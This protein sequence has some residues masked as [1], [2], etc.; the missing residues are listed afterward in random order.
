MKQTS[1][2]HAQAQPHITTPKSDLCGCVASWIL[3]DTNERGSGSDTHPKRALARENLRLAAGC[4]KSGDHLR[5]LKIIN[6]T[7]SPNTSSYFPFEP[8]IYLLKGVIYSE[9]KNIKK[10]AKQV[11]MA[12]QAFLDCLHY[13]DAA[14][15]IKNED[16]EILKYY[17]FKNLGVLYSNSHEYQSASSCMTQARTF[18]STAEQ[19][20]DID[21]THIKIKFAAG[22]HQEA[23]QM[24]YDALP[25]ALWS[26]SASNPRSV[27]HNAKNILTDILPTLSI[28]LA[29]LKDSTQSQEATETI[30]KQF[31][32]ATA[33][34][35]GIA[36]MAY[37]DKLQ[38]VTTCGSLD[39]IPEVAFLQFI[40]DQSPTFSDLIRIVGQ[41]PAEIE[42]F[43]KR[44]ANFQ[45]L[46]AMIAK[47]Q[48]TLSEKDDALR[49]SPY[50]V[51]F[52]VYNNLLSAYQE[53]QSSYIAISSDSINRILEE[54][55][56]VLAF[57]ESVE[58]YLKVKATTNQSLADCLDQIKAIE[59]VREG[60]ISK[61]RVCLQEQ[62]PG[63]TCKKADLEILADE[64]ISSQ[65]SI[66][67]L[68]KRYKSNDMKKLYDCLPSQVSDYFKQNQINERNYQAMSKLFHAHSVRL[69][70]KVLSE[71]AHQLKNNGLSPVE[72]RSAKLF[73]YQAITCQCHPTSPDDEK[74]KLCSL[75]ELRSSSGDD[76]SVANKFLPI[77]QAKWALI[78]KVL[79]SLRDLQ[80]DPQEF[81]QS[82]CDTSRFK[83]KAAKHLKLSVIVPDSKTII[84]AEQ[85]D[86][87][88]VISQ[89]IPCADN[90]R[91]DDDITQSLAFSLRSKSATIAA[92]NI[93]KNILEILAQLKDQLDAIDRLLHP[94][95][96]KEETANSEKDK[97]N[98]DFSSNILDI[99]LQF[100]FRDFKGLTL[101]S[102][103][104]GASGWYS[105]SGTLGDAWASLTL[106]PLVIAGNFLSKKR[107]LGT[108]ELETLI[109]RRKAAQSVTKE[110]RLVEKDIHILEQAIPVIS[111]KKRFQ[112]LNLIWTDLQA[113]AAGP[114]HFLD[115]K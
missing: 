59:T 105:F 10:E 62:Y 106:L 48:A 86:I 19:K 112:E 53:Q 64:F 18:A 84:P 2:E 69:E 87:R 11:K 54:R 32:D 46:S 66:E 65:I 113:I 5:A 79:K 1:R 83:S 110:L 50:F 36:R 78:T 73:M 17:A 115:T 52:N 33:A 111:T 30:N 12:R 101:T 31:K 99:A 20:S 72:Y 51:V 42:S 63:S 37:A 71:M 103:L 25:F 98:I 61:V 67:D 95:G 14:Y 100:T 45:Q 6:E 27:Q 104:L 90:F 13:V 43:E 102:A 34:I 38:L 60:L 91:I 9:H 15:W 40:Q 75:Q 93:C 22:E 16:K 49:R 3:T 56:P 58:K 41:L 7:L 55:D 57:D 74:K 109:T 70:N 76:N 108:T 68:A 94:K 35:Y 28:S 97:P 39:K 77:V 107:Q 29:S 24:L 26:K 85:I 88:A 81:S 44:V 114:N 8:T 92:E 4:L 47:D 82:L 80:L 21:L 96:T 23:S 89:F